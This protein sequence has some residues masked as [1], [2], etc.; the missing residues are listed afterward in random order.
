MADPTW[1]NSDGTVNYVD[2]YWLEEVVIAELLEKAGAG[3]DSRADGFTGRPGP[4]QLGDQVLVLR[5]PWPVAVPR[6]VDRDDRETP[7]GHIVVST[8][9]DPRRSL[10]QATAVPHQHQRATGTGYRRPEN[11][12]D[13]THREITF[14]NAVR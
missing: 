12:G 4:A 11:A 8:D 2:C 5:G 9:H 13:L 6:R 14:A 1:T 7:A 10:V 3:E